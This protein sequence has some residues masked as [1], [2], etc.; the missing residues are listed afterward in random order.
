MFAAVLVKLEHSEDTPKLIDRMLIPSKVALAPVDLSQKLLG[1][2]L[3]DR[4]SRMPW[5]QHG[6]RA[7][8]LLQLPR[9]H[10]SDGSRT[11]VRTQGRAVSRLM[12][13]G[14][15]SGDALHVA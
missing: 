15:V 14:F 10:P 8:Q 11:H 13:D 1:L 3:R 6:N 4:A 9:P 12:L 5:R 7:T 2:G